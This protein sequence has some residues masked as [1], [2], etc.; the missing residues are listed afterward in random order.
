MRKWLD[1]I[2]ALAMIVA[3]GFIVWSQVS[4]SSTSGAVFRKPQRPLPTTPVLIEG[5]AYRGDWT[6]P[7]IMTVFADFQCPLCGQFA[8]ETLLAFIPR[9]VD[10]GKVLLVFRNWP[11]TAIH[12]YAQEAASAAVCAARQGRFWE[13]HDLLF[14]SGLSLSSST[15]RDQVKTLALNL[16]EFQTCVADKEL[17]AQ[18][19]RDVDAGIALGVTGTPASLVGRRLD[20]TRMRLQARIPGA[21]PFGELVEIIESVLQRRE[22]QGATEE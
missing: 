7:L 16:V 3:S 10:T 13:L 15:I 9:Y 14:Q 6:A 8:R 4:K 12:P 22:S 20:A 18:I 1:G 11:L 17:A 19:K 2:A 5:V 21:V